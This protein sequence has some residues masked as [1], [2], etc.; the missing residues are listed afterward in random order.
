MVFFVMAYNSIVITNILASD[1]INY[2]VRLGAAGQFWSHFI[3][4]Y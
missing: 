4:A 2:C 3:T 1:L